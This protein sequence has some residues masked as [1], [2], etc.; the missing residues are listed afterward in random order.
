MNRFFIG[1]IS[2]ILITGIS[3][4]QRNKISQ[5][6]SGT[7]TPDQLNDGWRTASL[8]EVDI[9]SG[10]L[11]F[12]LAN[13]TDTIYQGV[14]RIVIVKDGYLVLDKYFTGYKFEYSANRIR[15]MDL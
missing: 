7:D 6:I 10:K 13:I 4:A 12:L 15:K 5:A 2:L 8:E 1:F 14:H 9:D 11:S 3:C